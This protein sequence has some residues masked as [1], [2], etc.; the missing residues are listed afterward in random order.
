M[1]RFGIYGL[2]GWCGEVVW[3]AIVDNI[4]ALLAGRAIDRRLMGYTYLWMLPIYGAAGMVFEVA[5]AAMA[6]WVWPLRGL[7]YM[8]VCFAIEYAS[9]W[10]IQQA[11]GEIPWDY[12][13]RRWHVHGLIRLDYAPVW[14]SAG[15]LFDVGE[16]WVH[17]VESA[18][19]AA[20]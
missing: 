15:L 17:V 20:S 10:S 7:T 9:G 19:R 12:S 8:L 3:T 11:T 2:L 14:F 5:H 6:S 18:L 1:I 16:R 4:E 13:D